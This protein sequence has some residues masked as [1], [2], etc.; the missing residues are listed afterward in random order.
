MLNPVFCS[1]DSYTPYPASVYMS[2]NKENFQAPKYD[3][4]ESN[5][6]GGFA[7]TNYGKMVSKPKSFSPKSDRY[8]RSKL[9]QQMTTEIHVLYN[10]K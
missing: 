7:E 6:Q 2:Q 10:T 8:T 5:F 1:D 4:R 3:M 9:H